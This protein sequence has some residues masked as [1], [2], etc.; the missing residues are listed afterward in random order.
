M[1]LYPPSIGGSVATPPVT[2]I[3]VP[4]PAAGADWSY[5]LLTA[6][7]LANIYAEL[8]T[9]AGGATRLPSIGIKVGGDFIYYM[10]ATTSVG[11]VAATDYA[12]FNLYP[13]AALETNPTGNDTYQAPI[14]DLFLPEGA[15]IL[16]NT[17]ALAGTD[18]WQGI[19]LTMSAV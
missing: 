19:L 11:V 14:P 12:I 7:R 10:A 16:S 17:S 2:T 4:E 8:L 5:T 9:V 3:A 15:E 13:G 6:A 18:Q 1:P